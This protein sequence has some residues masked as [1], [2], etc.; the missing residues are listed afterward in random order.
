[1]FKNT[2]LKASTVLMFL[3]SLALAIAALPVTDPTGFDQ[4]KVADAAN[5]Q[6]PIVT[7]LG[8]A[9]NKST[10]KT[11]LD[12]S[13]SYSKYV[14]LTRVPAVTASPVITYD[15]IYVEANS[16]PPDIEQ[17]FRCSKLNLGYRGIGH[18]GLA[19]VNINGV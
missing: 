18:D 14:N 17:H 3:I 11:V 2:M 15:A 7:D 19:R 1:M 12:L 8:D 10:V 6:P 4:V 16:Y 5:T 9:L 13:G